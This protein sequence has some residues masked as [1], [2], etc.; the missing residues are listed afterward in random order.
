M[1]KKIIF[2]VACLFFDGALF[3]KV[4]IEDLPW[5]KAKDEDAINYAESFLSKNPVILEAGVCGGE[6]TICFKKKWPN[7]IIY[8]FEPHPENF[9]CAKIKTKDLAGVAIMN[10]ALFDHVGK[11]T[12]YK[13]ATIPA[14]SSLL[15]DNLNNIEIPKDLTLGGT[16]YR[17]TAATVDCT[18]VDHWAKEAGIKKIDFIWLDTEGAELYILKNAKT[19]LPT[20]RVISTEVNFK[21]FRLGMTY[22]Q[23][24][25]EFLTEQGF[26]L[27]Y[28]WGRSDWQGVAI[29]VHEVY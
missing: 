6:D 28:I 2:G 15:V 23:D 13:S 16:N 11:I 8:G 24:L 19:I 4:A 22:F 18:T 21:E 7:S 20:V 10:S 14:A 17:D 1:K 29:F 3:A 9:A 26:V 5:I 25:Y 27:K 12:F